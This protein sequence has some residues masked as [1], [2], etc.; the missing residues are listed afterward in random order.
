MENIQLRRAII[1]GP[2]SLVPFGI[3]GLLMLFDFLFVSTAELNEGNN[4]QNRHSKK[5]VLH[6]VRFV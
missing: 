1:T 5:Y 2:K 4:G 3:D 6:D